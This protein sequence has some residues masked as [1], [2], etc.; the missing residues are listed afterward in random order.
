VAEPAT[1]PFE[2]DTSPYEGRYEGPARGQR[3]TATVAAEDGQ[4]TVN[5]G[6]GGPATLSWLGGDE[7]ADGRTLYRFIRGGDAGDAGGAA[8]FNELRMDVISGHFVLRRV[9]P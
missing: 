4:L 9:N 8:P 2:G 1:P 5:T 6:V 7:F 3:I